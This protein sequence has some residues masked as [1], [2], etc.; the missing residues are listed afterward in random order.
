MRNQ[1]IDLPG[2][3]LT[4][5]VTGAA[6]TSFSN[7]IDMRRMPLRGITIFSPDTLT[8]TVSIEV[9]GNLDAENPSDVRWNNLQSGGAN[10]VIGADEAVPLDFVCWHGLRV[11]SGSA[12]TDPRVFKIMGVED[13]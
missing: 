2:G 10:V 13:I 7:F 3:I 4:I 6:A 9:S 5:P 12:E 8:G 1:P 11:S